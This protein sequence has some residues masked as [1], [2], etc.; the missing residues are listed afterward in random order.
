MLLPVCWA[1]ERLVGLCFVRFFGRNFSVVFHFYRT[2][3]C[4]RGLGRK[5]VHAKIVINVLFTVAD[6]S[7]VN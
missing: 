2:S 3:L 1:P 6:F 7:I 5:R 4:Y